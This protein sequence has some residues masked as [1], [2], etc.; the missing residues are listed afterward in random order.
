MSYRDDR[1]YRDDDRDHRGGGYGGGGGGYGGGG[2]G[3]GGG[4][5]G[6]G[7][8][9]GGYGGGR[10]GYGGGGGGPRGTRVYCGN[11]PMDI[12][13]REIDD[14]FYKYGRITDIHI[15]R[16]N[17]PPAF[18][19]ITFSDD[20]DAEDAVRARDGTWREGGR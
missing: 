1:D 16:P 4:G 6:Y 12:K 20:R 15:K 13:E 7:G 14:L 11:L 18:A 3:Y 9:G 2:G 19:F 10:G 17:R 5:G 8:G